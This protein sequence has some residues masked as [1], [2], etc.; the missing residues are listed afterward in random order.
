MKNLF[1]INEEEKNR[2]LNIH[3]SA[4]KR[5]YL[6]EQDLGQP[7]QSV[8]KPQNLQDISG[9]V[10]KQGSYG[11]PYVYAK[12]GNDY[13]YSKLSDGDN[14]NWVLAT[15]ED[16]IKSIKSKIFN[17]KIPKIKTITPPEKNKAKKQ[18]IKVKTTDKTKTVVDKT[19]KT[20]VIVSDKINPKFK[21]ILDISKLSVS[22]PVDIFDAGQKNCAT[23]IRQ[24][25]NGLGDVGDAWIA[26]DNSRL[27]STIWSSFNHLNSN[28]IADV[29]DLWKEINSAGGGKEKGPFSSKVVSFVN[30][31]VP[32]SPGVSLKLND[33]VGLFYP[34]SKHHEEAF[35]AAGKPFFKK[36]IV[37][38]TVNGDTIK[39]GVGWGMNTHIG[40]V[41]AIKDGVPLI[42][43]NIG[44]QVWADPYTNLKGG[45]RIAWVKRG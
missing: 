35:Y 31:L 23:F 43:H 27:G 26:Y 41:G 14:P 25:I 8:D 20:G 2:I 37:G 13:Y 15:K 19:K 36:N 5:H 12:L 22:Y 42:F 28:Q 33:I 38:M 30:G 16:S 17:E 24:F 34:G 44:G 6:P 10:I 21:S 40:V 45:A 32:K 18:P 3:E 29:T 7:T 4:T 11:D 1:I 39:K 9:T